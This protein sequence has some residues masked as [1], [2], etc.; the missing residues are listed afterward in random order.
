MIINTSGSL[1]T[2]TGA[3]IA[4]NIWDHVAAVKNSG[5]LKM[6][7]NGIE[8]YSAA[9][10]STYDITANGWR[11]GDDG[12]H[13]NGWMNGYIS[14]LRI[15]KGTAVYTSAFTPPTQPLT[16][17]ANTSLLTLQYNGGAT[18]QA[19]IDN[20]SFNNIITRSGNTSQGSF[21]PYSVTGWS[22]YFDGTGDYLTLSN[23]TLLGMGSGNFT[24]EFWLYQAALSNYRQILDVVDGNSAGRLILWVGSDGTLSNLGSSGTTR[25]TTSSGAIVINTW[26]HVALVRS[27]G[28]TKFYINGTQSGSNYTDSTNYTCTTGTVYIGINSD[29]STYPY[30][31]Y[32]SNFRMIKG[33]AV[34]TSAFTPS[35]TPLTAITNTSILTCQSNR[36][37]D[38]SLNSF[39]ITRNGDTS[40]QALDPFGSVPEAVPISYSNY[41]DGTDDNL[42][43][44]GTL[45]AAMGGGF[46]GNLTTM[47]AWIYTA[48][49]GN[50]FGRY[51]AIGEN[52]RFYWS[53]SSN[54]LTFLWTTSTG[55][56][57]S[58]SSTGSLVISNQWN[59]VAITIDATTAS[60]SI[61]KMF[62]NG[63][64]SNTFTSQNLSSQTAF[65]PSNPPAIGYAASGTSAFLGY[66]SNFRVVTGSLVY[67]ANFTP[68]TT[69]LT[70]I[71]NT[72]L[73]TCQSTTMID[74]SAN[75][76]TVTANGDTKPRILNPFGYTSQ[77]YTSYTPSL[78]GG[79]IY[80]DGTGDSLTAPD[81]AFNLTTTIWCIEYWIYPT[82]I[83]SGYYGLWALSTSGFRQGI[84]TDSGTHYLVVLLGGGGY[85]G[86]SLVAANKVITI[87][88]WQHI[89]LTSDGTT[90]RQFYNGVLTSTGSVS[91]FSASA[92]TVG[93]WGGANYFT[94]Y[95]SD[96]R[97]TKGSA[98]Y[99]SNFVPPTTSVTAIPNTT[100]LLNF[101]NG[102]II[103]LHGS[104]VLETLGNTQL[105]TSVK[106]YGTSSIYFDG[107]G[108]YLYSP[109][110][111]NYAMGSGNFTIEFWYYPI[112][113]NPAWNPNIMGNYNATWTSNKWAFHAPH[114]VYASKYS[115]W[116][117]NYASNS[118]ILV[119]TSNITNG[120][121]AHIAI[122]RSGS[123]WRIFV[124]GTI[125][126]TTTSSV[127]LD[128]G[129]AASMDGFYVGANFYSGEGGRYINA[130]MDDLRI[131]KGYA[132]YT[133]NFT[134]PT[135]ALGG[136]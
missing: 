107:T 34:Y 53:V 49:N 124:N 132:R 82:V 5:V 89:A 100:L 3:S 44:P 12:G 63:T 9:D 74:N 122:T 64:L 105:S 90:I 85:G 61:I 92:P 75:R 112:S 95:M 126:A 46:A 29:G 123:T 42:S 33:T 13:A 109:P 93:S 117:N 70:A 99:T 8:R 48:T 45:R 115:F 65:A 43:F 1:Q 128:G 54:N 104:N 30:L 60:S 51:D 118:A 103:D 62:I 76:F 83:A 25:H 77:T 135:S 116:V 125:E 24:V 106:K 129:T 59:H 94:G 131:T 2:T 73:L 88:N 101:N 133:S 31:G 102:G 136:R 114:A 86:F 108:D 52:G 18:N 80:L 81:N 58:V 134:P 87:N 7:I 69:P 27:S 35:T 111:I 56:A 91:T 11:I 41:F 78:H 68:S 20:S 127:A 110:S 10:S 66:I 97:I 21:S 79:S 72:S 55:A 17:I 47:E 71:A 119:S 6:F 38:N 67:T 113:Q 84:Y 39:A 40:V 37:I 4:N 120:A 23:N 26:T 14:D 96:F 28:T 130:Y 22:N 57:T 36:F 16:A 32:I 121:W 19:I 15:V 98:I 50:I